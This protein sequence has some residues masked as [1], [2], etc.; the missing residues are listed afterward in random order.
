[1][2]VKLMMVNTYLQVA[3]ILLDNIIFITV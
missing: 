2:A 3:L 1:L